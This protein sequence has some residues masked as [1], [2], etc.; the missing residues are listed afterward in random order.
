[1]IGSRES[2]I[3]EIERYVEDHYKKS[4]A[5]QTRLRSGSERMDTIY[6]SDEDLKTNILMDITIEE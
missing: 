5:F 2:T 6:V 1:M 3:A 4:I